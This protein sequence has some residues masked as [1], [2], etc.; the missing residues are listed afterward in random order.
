QRRVVGQVF[1]VVVDH[2]RRADGTYDEHDR[3]ER[4]HEPQEPH[5][6]THA[7]LR[8]INR[9]AAAVRISRT[10]SYGPCFA[11]SYGKNKGLAHRIARIFQGN[12]QSVMTGPSAGHAARR[13]YPKQ[14]G[15]SRAQGLPAPRSPP[16]K[17]A[18]ARP[19][20]R[21][22]RSRRKRD[23]TKRRSPT[24]APSYGSR[25]RAARAPAPEIRK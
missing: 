25:C 3:A 10:L 2:Q 22:Y 13:N 18:C 21:A 5:K 17:R 1:V 7:G 11:P 12:G 9:R 20:C 8:W 4:E 24:R 15:K 6:K 14:R 19:E 16:R 23:A